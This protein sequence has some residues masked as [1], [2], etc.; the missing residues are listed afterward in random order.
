[1]AYPTTLDDNTTLPEAVNACSDTLSSA[2]TAGGTT[3]NLTD[4]TLFPSTGG[5]IYVGGERTTYTGKTSNQLTGVA[6]LSNNYS[7]GAAVRMT[8]DAEHINLLKDAVVALETK[9]GVTGSTVAGTVEKRLA[10]IDALTAIANTSFS[11]TGSLQS[12][13]TGDGTAYT[14]LFDTET[15]DPGN[16]FASNTFT[17]PVSG[18]YQLNLLMR[19]GDFG[20]STSAIAAIVTSNR[21]YR[22]FDSWASTPPNAYITATIAVLADMDAGDTATINLTVSGGTKTTDI[23]GTQYLRF[24]GYRVC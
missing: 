3:L 20:T 2:Y 5:I 4:A 7:A 11:V 15:F 8:V 21:E 12:N 22:W 18:K 23:N 9:V 6:A 24:S 13:V 1:M 17:A 19:F 10:D 16:N 14:V